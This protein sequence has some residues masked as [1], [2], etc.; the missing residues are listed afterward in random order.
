VNTLVK[1]VVCNMDVDPVM[2]AGSV[3]HKGKSYYFC[4]PRCVERFNADPE[5]YLLPKTLP[6]Q[7]VQ[8]GGI[9]L[10][11]Q[12][13][14][15][16]AAAQRRRGAY[17]CPMDPE[18]RESKPG[19]CPVCGMGLEN[20][21]RA[22]VEYTCPMHP[23]IVRDRPGACPICGMALEPRTLSTAPIE[24]DSE[25]RI[26]QQRFWTGVALSI[27][28]LLLSMGSM[29]ADKLVHNFPAGSLE[30]LQ[31]L[32]AT[33]VVLWGGWPFFQRGWASLVSRQLN[34]FTLIALGTSAAFGFSLFAEIG[35]ASCRERV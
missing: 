23:E 33:P 2:A 30:W 8:L 19:P 1:D 24:D 13:E 20:D 10:A 14:A 9:Q 21:V 25:L 5:R 15:K 17:V 35:R 12:P 26:M 16:A 4:S 29:A 3:E 22:A 27:P 34:M 18:V 31:V 11:R 6:G 32:L 7:L 28:L